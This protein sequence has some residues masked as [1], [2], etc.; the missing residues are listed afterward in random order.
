MRRSR[1]SF[2]PALILLLIGATPFGASRGFAQETEPEASGYLPAQAGKTPEAGEKPTPHEDPDIS[3]QTSGIR[4]RSNLVVTPVTVL[5]GA[6][7]FIYGLSEQDFQIYDNGVL[8][9][10]TGFESEIRA[11]SVVI[12]VETNNTTGPLL[13]QVQPLGPVFTSQ[14]LGAEGQAAVITY[15][16]R[17]RVVQD[18]SS[19]GDLLD[20]TF[21]HLAV[22]GRG[23]RLDDALWRALA[24]LESRPKSDRRV[25]IAFS[26]GFDAG[27]GTRRDAIIRRATTD[28]IGIYGLGFS[29]SRLLLANP[30]ETHRMSPEDQNVTRPTPSGEPPTPSASDATYGTPVPGIPILTD[31]GRIIRS[32]FA[33]NLLEIYAGYTGGVF[34]SHWKE[35]ALQNQLQQVASEIQSQYELGYV[36]NT[37][38]QMGFHRITVKVRGRGFKVRARAG[39]FFGGTTP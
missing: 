3:K 19:D 37:L 17:V 20:K 35:R 7:Q 6:G 11:L 32:K 12:V 22:S 16:D 38:G 13:E 31:T 21:K 26:D 15:D 25:I 24:M 29:P 23:A 10:L 18:F 2:L 36:P 34:Y 30:P 8:Q 28:G 5:D 1:K 4:I 27:S 33:K 9:R 39:Y 14:L